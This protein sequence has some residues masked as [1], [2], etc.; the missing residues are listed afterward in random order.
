MLP[1]N[2]DVA[3]QRT[4]SLQ[5]V[6]KDS[7]YA[8]EYKA[9]MEIVLQK[10]YAEKV[11]QERLPKDLDH[12]PL[13]DGEVKKDFNANCLNL[14]FNATTN[15]IQYYSSWRKLKRSCCMAVEA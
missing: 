3:A 4:Q 12:I 14:Q 1:N 9:F 2:H 10:G 15:L 6:R 7:A 8:T 11:P 13:N 5:G